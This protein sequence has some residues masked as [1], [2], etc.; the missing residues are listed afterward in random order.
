[1][2]DCIPKLKQ[3]VTEKSGDPEPTGPFETT[4]SVDFE[5]NKMHAR[6]VAKIHHRTMKANGELTKSR[7]SCAVVITF[8]PFC[9]E[10]MNDHE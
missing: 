6:Q 3:H 4:F 2:C 8:C 1:M 10:K 7:K 5:S 9:G